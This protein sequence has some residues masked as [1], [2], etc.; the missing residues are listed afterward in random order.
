MVRRESGDTESRQPAAAREVDD[1]RPDERRTDDQTTQCQQITPTGEEG[2]GDRELSDRHGVLSH[3]PEREAGRAAS[4]NQRP[5]DRPPGG[6]EDGAAAFTIVVQGRKETRT[7]HWSA[8]N[9]SEPTSSECTCREQGY[10]SRWV[11][12]RFHSRSTEE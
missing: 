4:K 3:A 6:K 12:R 7:R 8:A 2:G 11:A 1:P 10:F 5:I 9:T